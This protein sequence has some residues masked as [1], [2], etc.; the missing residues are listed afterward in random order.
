MKLLKKSHSQSGQESF[1]L[2]MLEYKKNGTYLEVG[3]WDGVDLSN[4]YLLESEYGWSGLAIDINKDYVDRYNK[5]RENICLH[6]DALATNYE[7]LLNKHNFPEVIDYL[8]LDIEP[9]ENT[10]KCLRNIPFDSFK[11]RTIT[12]EHDLYYSSSN[13][14]F[15]NL[16][17][18]FLT[19]HGYQRIADNVQNQGN[20]YEDWYVHPDLVS[21][22]RNLNFEP[23]VDFINHFES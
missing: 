5:K 17:F 21:S 10:F 18:E 16:A 12:F 6:A 8:Q 15:K 7:E 20:P 4:T 9:A 14:V 3:A 2:N 1:V 23:D 19:A 13:L 11:F 22:S